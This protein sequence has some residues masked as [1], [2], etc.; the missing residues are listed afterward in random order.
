MQPKD[1]EQ[2]ANGIINSFSRPAPASAGC[3][4]ISNGQS[5]LCDPVYNCTPSY[6]C[7]GAAA[8]TCVDFTCEIGA[9]FSCLQSF[10]FA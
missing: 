7:G 1:I 5:Y 3:G 4:S 8:F 9:A 2:I 10:G 6:E